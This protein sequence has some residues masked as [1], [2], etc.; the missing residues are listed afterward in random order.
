[1]TMELT[2][3]Q[4]KVA[5][6]ELKRYLPRSQQMY[7]FVV[8]RNRVAS[9]RLQIVVDK[10]P[11]FSVMICKPPRGQENNPF[12]VIFFFATDE[13]ILEETIK[14]TSVIDWTRQFGLG[15]NLS[16]LEILKKVASE[17]NVPCKKISVC[18]MMRLEDVSKLPSIDSSRI[19]L[20]SL[21]ESHIGLVNDTW[22]FGKYEGAV[23]MIRSMISKFPSCCVL[24][25]DGR[26]VSWILTYDSCA[27]GMLYTVP[28]HRGKG[29]AKVLISS[30]AKR[31]HALGHP[32]YC[33][34]EEENTASYRLFTNLGFIEDPSYREAWFE[35]NEY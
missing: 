20:S 34:I 21:D 5:E 33:F 7:G 9:H 13:V 17:K 11:K 12:R 16:H 14:K 19:S 30:M 26:P 35:F 27:M 23:G 3:D 24:G 32:V 28:E 29:Y 31:H 4:L 2:D 6:T 1:M 10:W 25:A 18:H 8:L 15:I 22:K